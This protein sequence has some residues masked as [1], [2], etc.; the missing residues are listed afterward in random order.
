MV[1][2][3][4][5]DEYVTDIVDELMEAAMSAIYDKYIESQLLPFTITQ[6]RDAITEIIEV[7]AKIL[8]ICNYHYHF[9]FFRFLFSLIQLPN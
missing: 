3:D 7:S 9:L 4:G 8:H 2:R 5:A 6:A 1:D